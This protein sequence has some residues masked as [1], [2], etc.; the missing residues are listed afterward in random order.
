MG[1]RGREYTSSFPNL[2][3]RSL[4][5]AVLPDLHVMCPG[6]HG[7]KSTN[8]DALKVMSLFVLHGR[9]SVGVRDGNDDEG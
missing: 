8:N 5:L 1:R 7:V 3:R 6:V 9:Q 4:G 2:V